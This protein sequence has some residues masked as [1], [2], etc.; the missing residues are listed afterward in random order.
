MGSPNL[1]PG[2]GFDR[3]RLCGGAGVSGALICKQCRGNA[4]TVIY[5]PIVECPLCGQDRNY[6]SAIGY[7]GIC[8]FC[9]NAYWVIDRRGSALELQPRRIQDQ[10]VVIVEDHDELREVLVVA[11]QRES[12]RSV[13]A[14]PDGESAIG[15]VLASQ[16]LPDLIVTD[17]RMPTMDGVEM[18]RYLK[19]DSR[20]SQIPV[21]VLTGYPS[22]E[23]EALHAGA[24]RVLIKPVD[25][26]IFVDSVLSLLP[27][28][29][30]PSQ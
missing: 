21:L 15:V 7:L 19:Q 4:D 24:D 26:G 14:A 25:L 11:L 8:I 18:I 1:P 9:T 29:S 2:Y 22:R 23:S 5:H 17:L 20:L 6:D 3:C 27:Y 16:P 12:F 10:T 13:L 30:L 28:Q